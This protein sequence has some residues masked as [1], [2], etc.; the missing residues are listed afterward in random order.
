MIPNSYDEW[1]H[2]ITVTCRQALTP[3]YITGRLEAL[4][5]PDD[6]GTRRFR[7]L[8]GSEH[9]NDIQSWFERALE[10]A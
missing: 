5:S 7:E 6:P 3:E 1:K 2:C 10:E 9:L 8:Y 4:R